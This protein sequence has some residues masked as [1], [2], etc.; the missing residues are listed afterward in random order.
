LFRETNFDSN[1]RAALESDDDNVMVPV[2]GDTPLGDV[3][4][5]FPALINPP[6]FYNQSELIRTDIELVSGVTEFMRGG[7]SEIRRTATEAALIQDA[8]NARTADKLA[9]IETTVAEVG[10]RILLLAQQYMGGEQV[11]RITARD[12]EPMW[13]TFDR[14]YLSGDFD[15]DVAAGSTQPTNE[16]YRRQS[17]MQMVDAMAPF[18]SAGII[19]VAKLGAYVLQYGFNVKNP[20]MFMTQPEQP[21]AEMMPPQQQPPMPPVP[22]QQAAPMIGPP[23]QP[24]M[25]AGGEIPPELLAMLMAGGDMGGGAPPPMM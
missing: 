3:V 8:Q 21:T 6:E 25:G 11:A 24:Q 1:G 23:P 15:F 22:M 13:V 20:E 14:E 12:G 10:R 17:A 2:S 9:V 5:P 18:V 16:A 19:D 4:A 7:V